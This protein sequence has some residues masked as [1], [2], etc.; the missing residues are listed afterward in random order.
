MTVIDAHQH[1]WRLDTGGYD[2]ITDEISGIRRDYHPDH[3]RP[4]LEHLGVDKTVLVQAREDIDDNRFMMEMAA[5]GGF[6]GG[7]VAW[8]DL[9]APDAVETLEDLAQ[10]PIIKA[11]RPVLQGIE[12]TDWILREDVIGALKH[13]PRLGLRF[14]ALITPRH[15]KV[16]DTLAKTI[17]DLPMVVDHAAKP[18][19][20]SGQDAGEDW[21]SGMSQLAS[22][23]QIMCKISGMVT[24]FGPGWTRDALQPVA[25]HLISAFS[26][27]RLMWGSDWPVL[28]LDGSYPQWFKTVG[29]LIKSCS[30]TEQQD[31]RGLTAARFYGIEI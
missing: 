19:I 28:E 21:R 7:I 4:Y 22:H 23:P 24:E 8:V 18:V 12:Q 11:V 5:Q 17:P 31:I 29:Q 6:V 16:I 27:N 14:D 13:L 20:L 26:P 1:F 15:L 10:K 25:D 9:T 30:T 2:W 3:L